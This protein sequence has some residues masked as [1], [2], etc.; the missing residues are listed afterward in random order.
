M[1]YLKVELKLRFFVCCPPPGTG[2]SMVMIQLYARL[3]S[4]VLAWALLY[5]IYCFRDPLPW[6]TCSNPWNTGR[7]RIRAGLRLV[8]TLLKGFAMF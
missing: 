7:C 5:L 8:A 3:Y 2:F 6:A 4:I 1:I